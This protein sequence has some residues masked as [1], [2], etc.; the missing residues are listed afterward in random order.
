MARDIEAKKRDIIKTVYLRIRRIV[1]LIE[2]R[3]KD[4]GL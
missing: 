2:G 3:V 4:D 1:L